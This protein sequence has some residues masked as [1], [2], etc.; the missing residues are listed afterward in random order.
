MTNGRHIHHDVMV[1]AARLE[2]LHWYDYKKF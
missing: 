1:I 2:T